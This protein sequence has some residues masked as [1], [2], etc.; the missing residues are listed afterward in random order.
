MVSGVIHF[1]DTN[2]LISPEPPTDYEVNIENDWISN[3][4][5]YRTFSENN[6]NFSNP[7]YTIQKVLIN[8]IGIVQK[9]HF[10]VL[11]DSI[12]LVLLHFLY[13]F[14]FHSKYNM[15]KRS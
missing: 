10:T 8:E 12:I 1:D 15:E 11:T 13:V 9:L 5:V 6:I 2:H 14:R 7:Y 3:N 4:E